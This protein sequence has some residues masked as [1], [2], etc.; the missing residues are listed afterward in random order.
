MPWAPR[1]AT[2]EAGHKNDGLPHCIVVLLSLA[3]TPGSCRAV[4]RGGT[5]ALGGVGVVMS[6]QPASNR[7]E[8][9]EANGGGRR[10]INHYGQGDE[11]ARAIPEAVHFL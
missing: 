4:R 9:L 7:W 5:G 1:S 10:L 11:E 6:F 2:E 3:L 8:R